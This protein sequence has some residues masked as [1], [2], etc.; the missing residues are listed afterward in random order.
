M[1]RYVV[2]SPLS[3]ARLLWWYGEDVLWARAL[4][5]APETVAL[6]SE[7]FAA[8]LAHPEEIA[9][10]WPSPPPDAYLLIPTIGELEGEPRP[11]ARRQRRRSAL[12]LALDV[13]EEKRWRDPQLEAVAWMVDRM[14]GAPDSHIEPSE[15]PRLQGRWAAW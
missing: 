15:R 14:S 13:E 10:L 1:I 8:L 12:P 6:L 11:A 3:L 7:D 4:V 2:T 9:R 5:L